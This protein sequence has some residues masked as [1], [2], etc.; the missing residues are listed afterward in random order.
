ML[1]NMATSLFDRGF[2][3]TTVPKAK[4]VKPVID[5]MI[6]LAK[7]GDLSAIRAVSA[8]LTKPATVKSLFAAAKD[9]YAN[10][11]CG[12]TTMVRIGFRHGDA[13]PMC[14]L[15]LVKADDPFRGQIVSSKS[16]DRERRVAASRQPGSGAGLAKAPAVDFSKV[17][18]EEPLE[19]S[20]EAVAAIDTETAGETASAAGT[21]TDDKDGRNGS[22]D[23]G[24]SDS[25]K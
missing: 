21:E 3:V 20:D 17:T 15:T 24:S 1:R 9:R 10:R 16:R 2:I 4:A 18:A 13:A 11:V 19:A 22:P 25:G 14:Q 23:P 12:Y 7:R 8:V 5:R 6:T